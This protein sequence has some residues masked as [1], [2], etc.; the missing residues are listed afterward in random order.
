MKYLVKLCVKRRNRLLSLA[1]FL[2][3]FFFKSSAFAQ[4]DLPDYQR[5]MREAENLIVKEDYEN[6]VKKLSAAMIICPDSAII[7]QRIV[8]EIFDK[9]ENLAKEAGL[10]ETCVKQKDKAITFLKQELQTKGITADNLFKYF[11]NEAKVK[12]GKGLYTEAIREYNS[13][14]LLAEE[15]QQDLEIQAQ[16]L[17]IDTIQALLAKAGQFNS[18]QNYDVA[19]KKYQEILDKNP[20]DTTT[21]FRRRFAQMLHEGYMMKVPGG[22]FAMGDSTSKQENEKPAHQVKL[23][24]FYMARHEVTQEL[25]KGVMGY[26][27][28][29]FG[30]NPQNPVEQVSW[31]DVVEFCN[32]LSELMGLKPGY[33]IQKNA[34]SGEFSTDLFVGIIDSANGFRLPTEAEWEYAAR[35]GA[36][37]DV[38][39]SR[40][41]DFE[42]AGSDTLDSV[43]WYWKNSGDSLLDGEWNYERIKKNNCRTH[44]VGQLKANQLGL[45]DMSGNVWEWCW[46]WYAEDYYQQCKAEG[47]IDNPFG[48]QSGEYRV[49]RGGSWGNDTVYCRVADRNDGDPRNGWGDGGFRLCLACSS[50]LSQARPGKY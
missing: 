32:R 13:A 19:I 11:F 46:D 23:D 21:Q 44:P 43:G 41:A 37:S 17:K 35:G 22:T 48:S 26:N 16:L 47:I 36:K 25:F 8:V 15:A 38:E 12:Y 34:N 39:R 31:Y 49:L 33:N 50:P 24:T 42:Y 30:D 14:G 6:A 45:Y 3:F 9:I 10:K 18:Q 29:Y 40:N 28:S 20:T 27:P 1:I 5:L 2:F 7:P 4:C